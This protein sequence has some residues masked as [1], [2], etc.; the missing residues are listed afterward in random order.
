MGEGARE[1]VERTQARAPLRPFEVYKQTVENTLQKE[2]VARLPQV[3]L[4]ASA[5]ERNSDMHFRILHTS[6]E[7][8]DT[9]N[10]V[11]IGSIWLQ[12][13]EKAGTAYI[14]NIDIH[15]YWKENEEL[16]F[17]YAAY[18]E[19]I[20]HL[21]SRTPPLRLISGNMLSRGALGVWR[22]FERMGI[23][24]MTDEGITDERALNRGY[25][26]A[27]FELI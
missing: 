2:G 26:T 6:T 16:R 17:G 1:E 19:L 11:G 7:R 18:L 24:R 9:G 21:L 22:G 14:R 15:E 8:I 25:S 13:D 20:R 5:D 3:E 12:T 4:D 27:K 10:R 23:A